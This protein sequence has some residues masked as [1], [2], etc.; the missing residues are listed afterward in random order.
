MHATSTRWQHLYVLVIVTL[1]SHTLRQ[2]AALTV[3]QIYTFP[4]TNFLFFKVNYKKR[5]FETVITQ[6]L[7]YQYVS[8]SSNGASGDASTAVPGLRPP[9]E[10]T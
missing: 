10:R 9:G 3:S 6:L 2:M 4:D 7:Q 1:P 5:I 8:A